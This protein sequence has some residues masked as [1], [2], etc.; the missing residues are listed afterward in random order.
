MCI[1]WFCLG[2][3]GRR[4]KQSWDDEIIAAYFFKVLQC[5]IWY[6]EQARFQIEEIYVDFVKFFFFNSL[7]KSVFPP[8]IES[9]TS[10]NF[11]IFIVIPQ[12]K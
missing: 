3:Y 12:L 9:F 4:K 8:L 5:K 10:Y 7:N 11:S 6:F 2:L 1:D